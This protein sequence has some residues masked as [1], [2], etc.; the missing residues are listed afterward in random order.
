MSIIIDGQ[1]TYI[2]LP[3]KEDP[4]V[5]KKLLTSRKPN[6][7]KD[8][9]EVIY[10]KVQESQTELARRGILQNP[11][12][13][14]EYILHGC[15]D[16]YT[17]EELFTDYLKILRKRVGIN[18]SPIVYRRYENVRDLFY[19]HI[20]KNKQVS[21]IT[22]AVVSDFYAELNMKYE[23]TTASGMIAKLKTIVVFAIDNDKLKINPFNGVKISK[24]TKEVEFL[25][26]P[27]INAIMVKP[28]LGRLD[29][30]RDIFLFQCFTGLSFSDMASLRREDF[31]INDSGQLYVKKNRKKTGKG[32]LVVLIDHAE[33]IARKYDFILP[34]L[35]NQ[36]Y[37]SYLKEIR[38][39]CGI[40]KPLHTHIGRHTAATYL[41][42]R[43][44]PIETVSKILG[45]SS[46]QQ[47]Q[48]YAKLLD[49]SVFREFKK[50]ESKIKDK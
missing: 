16:S 15:S 45:H 30:V 1:R 31:L 37:N 10:Q 9:L 42:N 44:I 34:V 8:Y 27:E 36:K 17:V 29:K 28:L 23:S 33:T 35:S 47:T 20:G 12:N 18:L 11:T 19:K 49:D 43:G 50:L 41:L 32:Y 3:R 14:K 13:L 5:F 7:L 40:S 38:D 6:N 2:S 21:E 46:I 26:E 48:H 24:R 39:L 25:T 4:K 22:K